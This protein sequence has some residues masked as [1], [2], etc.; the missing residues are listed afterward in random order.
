M[1][2]EGWNYYKTVK[3]IDFWPSAGRESL[4]TTGEKV[5]KVG[6]PK[7]KI[8]GQRENIIWPFN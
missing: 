7:F 6:Y 2:Q 5:G 1:V 3:E 8:R 4:W